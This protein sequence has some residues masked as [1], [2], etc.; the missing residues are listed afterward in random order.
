[1]S[2]PKLSGGGSSSDSFNVV[3]GN[4]DSFGGFK[5]SDDAVSNLRVALNRESLKFGKRT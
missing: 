1:M 2:S 3:L 4:G 5:G